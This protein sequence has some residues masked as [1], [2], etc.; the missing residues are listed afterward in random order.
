LCG[1]NG[2]QDGCPS[3][4]QTSTVRNHIRISKEPSVSKTFNFTWKEESAGKEIWR[5]GIPDKTSG[6][7]KHGRKPSNSS[8]LQPEEYRL[9]W[10]QH[11]FESD[12]PNGVDFKAGESDYAEDFNYIHW[13]RISEVGEFFRDEP[14]LD[15]VNNWTVRFDLD[16]AQLR[17]TKTATFTVQ[18]AGLKT[19]TKTRSW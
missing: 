4:S 11:D 13:S 14:Y 3:I 6:E 10:A 18:V 16:R 12:F 8:E 19:G 9:Y 2:E 5:I 1:V 17:R 15:N 7:F